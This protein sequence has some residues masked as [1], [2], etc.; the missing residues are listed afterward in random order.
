MMINTVHDFRRAVRNGPYAWLGGYPTFFI[1]DDGAALCH[2]CAKKERRNILESIAH[3][4]RD[5]WRVV[6][7]DINYED[8]HLECE[9]CG[10]HIESAY[11]ED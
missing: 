6:A 11:A 4:A 3:R 5:D 7:I 10:Q 1:C 8:P 9:H 2:A